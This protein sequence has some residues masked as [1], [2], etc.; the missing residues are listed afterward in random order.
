MKM[1]RN[2]LLKVRCLDKK[3]LKRDIEIVFT[4]YQ[5]AWELNWGFV[6]MTKREFDA[7]VK[8]LLPIVDPEFV[9]IAEYDG[10]PCGFSVALPDYNQ[11]LHKIKGRLTPFNIFK[12]LYHK[13]KIDTVRIITM[14]VVKEH[15]GKGIDALFYYYTWKTGMEKG[16]YKGEFSWVLETNDMMNKIAQKHLGAEVYKKYRVYERKL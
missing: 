13:S 7:L 2:K 16:I 14:G 5:K 1:E 12:A 10:S 6:P 15:Q 4:L 11:V 9:F 3:N 8:N